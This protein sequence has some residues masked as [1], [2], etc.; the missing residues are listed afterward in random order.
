MEVAQLENNYY[1]Q[2]KKLIGLTEWKAYEQVL[3]EEKERLFKII[4]TDINESL[5]LK[6]IQ[7]Q[8]MQINRILKKPYEIVSEFEKMKEIEGGKRK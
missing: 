4:E 1:P 2:L 7:T 6:K 3:N 5:N 8:I